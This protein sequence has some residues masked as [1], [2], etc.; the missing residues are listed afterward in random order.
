MR[1]ISEE[2]V[3]TTVEIRIP[4]KPD[5]ENRLQNKDGKVTM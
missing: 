3:G 2:G 5:E 4:E 1:I